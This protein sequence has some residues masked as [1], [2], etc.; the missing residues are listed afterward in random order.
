M[1]GSIF[2]SSCHGSHE[3]PRSGGGNASR[4]CGALQQVHNDLKLVVGVVVAELV[5][6]G[7]HPSEEPGTFNPWSGR[8]ESEFALKLHHASDVTT[9]AAL[10]LSER[11]QVLHARLRLP[12]LT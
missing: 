4:C 2:R 10:K 1:T 6:C 11:V 3:V 8:T 7:V 9:Q 12:R 5:H